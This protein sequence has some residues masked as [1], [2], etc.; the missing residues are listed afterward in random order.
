M[1]L[2]CPNST[3]PFF[4]K[5]TSVHKSGSYFRKNDAR[6]IQRYQCNHC[7][8]KF[9]K[10]TFELECGQKKRRVNIPLLK[11]YSSGVSI[12][13]S[14]L[15]LGVH[16]ITVARKIRYLAKKAKLENEKLLAE[17]K[18]HK[19]QEVQFDDLVTIEHTKLKPLT[20][21]A[22]VYGKTRLILGA[23]VAQIPSSGLLASKRRFKY[24]RRHNHHKDSLSK[25]F[26]EL[27]KVVSETAAFK[28]DEHKLYPSFVKSY[29]PK[30]HHK[31]YK[32]GRGCVTGQGELKKQSFD[33][34]FSI[35]HTFA[36]MRANIN[37]LFRRTWCTTKDRHRLQDHIDIYSY[38]HNLRILK[39]L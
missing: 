10:S 28:S 35:N 26:D 19:I 4:K 21:S 36:M 13:R 32:G 6:K 24:G 16:P 11:L 20:V 31:R 22:A 7:K 25:L 37:R 17:L 5:S 34:L 39:K 29:F 2:G 9:S 8:K 23:Y 15:I 12:R 1:N 30:A 18:K 14:A 38:F 33:P 3:C 27:T